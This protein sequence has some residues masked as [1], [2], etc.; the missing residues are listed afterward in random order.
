MTIDARSTRTGSSILLIPHHR[1]ALLYKCLE[2]R[3]WFSSAA[4]TYFLRR[5]REC[6]LEL[7]SFS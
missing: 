5:I 1:T 2:S 4:K 6:S 3:S 7:L